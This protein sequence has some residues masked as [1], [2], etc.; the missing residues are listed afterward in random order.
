MTRPKYYDDDIQLLV[1]RIKV[2]QYDNSMT[3]T[4]MQYDNSM[5]LTDSYEPIEKSS[6]FH[7][8]NF[9]LYGGVQQIS[10]TNENR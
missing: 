3:L 7:S 4:V 9:V 5:T 2:M 10:R 8:S 1:Y 6:A